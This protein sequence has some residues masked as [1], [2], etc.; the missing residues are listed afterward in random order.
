MDAQVL[1]A[2]MHVQYS[3]R[4]AL[5]MSEKLKKKNKQTNQVSLKPPSLVVCKSKFVKYS[6][7]VFFI[8]SS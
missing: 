3:T 7:I 8:F 6:T 5:L 2:P 4:G 1:N